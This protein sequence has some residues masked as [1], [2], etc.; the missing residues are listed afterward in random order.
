MPARCISR[1]CRGGRSA[2]EN[3]FSRR[4]EGEGHGW[5]VRPVGGFFLVARRKCAREEV[6]RRC[7]PDAFLGNADSAALF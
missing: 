4:R 3:T 5:C 2:L 6:F 1:D 7:Q